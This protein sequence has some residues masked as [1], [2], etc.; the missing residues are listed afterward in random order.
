MANKV[1]QIIILI[2]NSIYHFSNKVDARLVSVVI[3]LA[4][5][6]VSCW[7]F[8]VVTFLKII[9]FTI[10]NNSYIANAIDNIAAFD[11]RNNTDNWTV[12]NVK[13]NNIDDDSYNCD[14][15]CKDIDRTN[16]KDLNCNNYRMSFRFTFFRFFFLKKN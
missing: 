7:W 9:L 10:T 8:V 3:R 11:N 13:V 2:I 5:V 4:L 6:Q 1:Q 12:N 15:N 14:D 16:A